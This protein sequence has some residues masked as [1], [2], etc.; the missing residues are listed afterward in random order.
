MERAMQAVRPAIGRGASIALETIDDATAAEIGGGIVTTEM[1]RGQRSAGGGQ[2]RDQGIVI[3]TANIRTGIAH[4]RARE[5][6]TGGIDREATSADVKM[7]VTDHQET[8]SMTA[9]EVRDEMRGVAIAAG[10]A[11]G[12]HTS[13]QGHA[14]GALIE[15]RCIS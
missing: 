5:N 7:I 8:V 11:A 9:R 6:K 10:A 1:G 4:G 12:R 14:E 15:W 3:T 13:T 2:D